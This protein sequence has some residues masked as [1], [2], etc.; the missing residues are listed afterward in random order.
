MVRPNGSQ[1]WDSLLGRH[2]NPAKWLVL[3]L[4]RRYTGMTLAELGIAAGGMDYAAVGMALK[5]LDRRI[6]QSPDLL[7]LEAQI[8]NMLDVKT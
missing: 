8:V 6:S 4:A 5:R 1:S 3:R 2:G 7:H